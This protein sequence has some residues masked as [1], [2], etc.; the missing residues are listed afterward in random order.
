[1]AEYKYTPTRPYNNANS[2]PKNGE[3]KHEWFSNH[4][5]V[6]SYS[7]I[8]TDEEIEKYA[9]I[10]TFVLEQM[11]GKRFQTEF[12][13]IQVEIGESDHF[14]TQVQTFTDGK[15]DAVMSYENTDLYKSVKQWKLITDKK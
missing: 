4:Y 13:E 5:A 12:E 11:V 8:L 14:Y 10:P 2:H 7:R 6:V 15:E 1:M 3:V 9:I